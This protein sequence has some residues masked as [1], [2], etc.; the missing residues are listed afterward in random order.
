M[1]C[2]RELPRVFREQRWIMLAVGSVYLTASIWAAH[3]AGQTRSAGMPDGWWMNRPLPVAMTHAYGPGWFQF[4]IWN[5]LRAI[6]LFVEGIVSLGY[7]GA[8]HVWLSGVHTG[9]ILGNL[10]PSVH[11]MSG[12]GL[13]RTGVG[14]LL[15][16]GPFEGGAFL[17]AWAL[18]IRAPLTL[19]RPYPGCSRWSSLRRLSMDFPNRALSHCSALTHRRPLGGEREP[20]FR[21][22]L[23][24][25]H[26]RISA[27][28]KESI[29]LGFSEGHGNHLGRQEQGN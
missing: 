22:S 29:G 12:G 10:A 24:F 6:L 15:P 16:H 7:L 28:D 27:H 3:S 25:E 20:V 14:V 1:A 23:H 2:Y 11:E 18:A 19:I 26:W 21:G 17:L 8:R 4:F 5:A 9:S 13:V